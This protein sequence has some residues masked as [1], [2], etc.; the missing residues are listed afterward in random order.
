MLN[1]LFKK[2]TENAG[3]IGQMYKKFGFW[4]TTVA[5]SCTL[6]ITACYLLLL[7]AVLGAVPYGVILSLTWLWHISPVLVAFTILAGCSIVWALTWKY[8]NRLFKEYS[9]RK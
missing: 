2:I 6:L 3:F 7:G 4:N 1:N 5:I 8:R 9:Y